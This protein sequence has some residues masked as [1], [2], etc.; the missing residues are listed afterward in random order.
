[1]GEIILENLQKGDQF[2]GSNVDAGETRGALWTR[3]I[4]F[5]SD[6]AK[7]YILVDLFL[8]PRAPWL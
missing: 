7:I 4:V 5:N 6:L 2:S 8:I 3:E 1:M